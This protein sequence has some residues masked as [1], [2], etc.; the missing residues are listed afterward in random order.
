MIP[1]SFAVVL[2]LINFATV[3]LL[4]V[5]AG[6]VVAAFRRLP[7]SGRASMLDA[8]AAIIGAVAVV[9][10]Y[11]GVSYIQRDFW[12]NDTWLFIIAIAAGAG[13]RVLSTARR[14]REP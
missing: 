12:A 10:F 14:D 11:V 9:L 7:Q 1:T 4:G 2:M 13:R 6:G 8:I 5:V 3:A